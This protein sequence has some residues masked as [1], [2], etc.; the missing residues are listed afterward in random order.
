MYRLSYE[1]QCKQC[2]SWGYEWGRLSAD[3]GSELWSPLRHKQLV[4]STYCICGLSSLHLRGPLT[5]GVKDCFCENCSVKEKNNAVIRAPF[6]PPLVFFPLSLSYFFP[7][8]LHY[9][10]LLYINIYLYAYKLFTFSN[11]LNSCASFL[12]GQ[13][14]AI[15]RI[16][17]ESVC[18]AFISKMRIW[19][20]SGNSGLIA[21]SWAWDESLGFPS[22]L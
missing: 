15:H 21:S 9:S 5:R 16:C 10:Q 14:M 1:S 4:R 2:R 11:H 13:Q 8:V 17:T 3:A 22:A 19:P 18:L 20:S 12:Q 7:L 6:P